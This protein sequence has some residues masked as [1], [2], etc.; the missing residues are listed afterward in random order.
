MNEPTNEPDDV[1]EPDDREPTSEMRAAFFADGGCLI[2]AT[3]PGLDI[4]IDLDGPLVRSVGRLATELG[5]QLAALLGMQSPGAIY[6]DAPVYGAV[7]GRIVNDPCGE[8]AVGQRW[9]HAQFGFFDDAG[10]IV[11]EPTE[12]ERMRDLFGEQRLAGA[13]PDAAAAFVCEVLNA[14]RSRTDIRYAWLNS[15]VVSSFVIDED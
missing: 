8:P 5:P 9:H 12:I 15:A 3:G 4:S 10:P 14:S 13:T 6:Q 11:L 2:D 7:G 1:C